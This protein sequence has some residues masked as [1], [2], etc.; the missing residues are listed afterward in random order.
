[1][2]VFFLTEWC[3]Q[4]LPI[5][6][7]YGAIQVPKQLILN[8]VKDSYQLVYVQVMQLFMANLVVFHCISYM[9][10]RLTKRTLQ[11]SY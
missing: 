3:L 6:Q 2:L 1:M 8:F 7:K 10:Q 9:S 4:Y 5:V 11:D